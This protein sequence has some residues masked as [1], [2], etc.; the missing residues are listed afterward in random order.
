MADQFPQNAQQT[1]QQQ[2]QSDVFTFPS[3]A[4]RFPQDV[5][6]IPQSNPKPKVQSKKD[7]NNGYVKPPRASKV[8]SLPLREDASERMTVLRVA[9]PAGMSSFVPDTAQPSKSNWS[10]KEKQRVSHQKADEDSKKKGNSAANNPSSSVE[11]LSPSNEDQ[12]KEW[13]SEEVDF[14]RKVSQYFCQPN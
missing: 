5:Q 6:S 4:A 3:T 1:H 8:S 10:T 14:F 11:P 13:S 2:N 9:P 7:N 12:P